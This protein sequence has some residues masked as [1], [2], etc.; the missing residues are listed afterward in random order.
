MGSDA[1]PEVSR[2]RG[3]EGAALARAGRSRVV[4]GDRGAVG[5]GPPHERPPVPARGSQAPLDRGDAAGSGAVGG[6]RARTLKPQPLLRIFF[7]SAASSC[8]CFSSQKASACI[9]VEGSTHAVTPSTFSFWT[10]Y[11]TDSTPSTRFAASLPLNAS[12]RGWCSLMR[13]RYPATSKS[14]SC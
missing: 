3:D 6:E 11:F 13:R 9:D 4:P 5:G 14:S 7:T 1:G 12:S 8:Q 10:P 2:D